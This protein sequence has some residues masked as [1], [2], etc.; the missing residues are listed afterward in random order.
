MQRAA[1]GQN[2]FVASGD[3]GANVGDIGWYYFAI[4]AE[5]QRLAFTIEQ[6]ERGQSRRYVL[7]RY[8]R[9][10]RR[11]PAVQSVCVYAEPESHKSSEKSHFACQLR[12]RIFGDYLN[13]G[14]AILVVTAN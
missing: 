11:Q 12:C 2:V 3:S 13:K 9:R 4:Y 5:L 6:C 8:F 14:I 7:S 1:Q 10:N